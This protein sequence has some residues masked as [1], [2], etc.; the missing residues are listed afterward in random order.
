[1]SRRGRPAEEPEDHVNNERWLL[2]YSDMITLLLALFIVLFAMSTINARKFAEFKSGFVL[3]THVPSSQLTSG[4]TG[5]LQKTSLVSHPGHIVSKTIT[6]LVTLE[7]EVEASL[8]KAG[9]AADAQVVLQRRGLVVRILSDK[10]F[11][12]ND[13]A[14]IGPVGVR[15]VA[16]IAAVLRRVPNLVDVE[17]YTDSVPIVGGPY[18]SNFELSAVRATNVLEELKRVDGIAA[19]R[20]SATGYGSTHPVATNATAAG[21]A[22]NRRVDVVILSSRVHSQRG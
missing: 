9:V 18:S 5:L 6:P 22:L 12:A 21:R 2:T 3:G 17:G 14:Q 7:S 1:M 15:V 13:S 20:L 4:G 16:A 19:D 8:T 11:F 10:V